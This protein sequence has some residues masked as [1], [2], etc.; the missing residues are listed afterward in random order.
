MAS[1][2]TKFNTQY[3]LDDTLAEMQTVNRIIKT[4]SRNFE[5]D[6]KGLPFATGDTLTYR[7]DQFYKTF[8]GPVM[9]DSPYTQSVGS[10]TLQQQIGVG[11]SFESVLEMLNR[12]GENPEAKKRMNG[13]ARQLSCA[14]EGLVADYF[15]KRT[16]NAVAITSVTKPDIFNAVR[17]KM[18]DL[19]IPHTSPWY[20]ATNLKTSVDLANSLYYNT[21][22][23]TMTDDAFREGFIGT[24]FDYRFFESPYMP[25]HES[26]IGNG[27]YDPVTLQRPAGGL[28]FSV[29]NGATSITVNAL[30]PSSTK[31]FRDGDIITIQGVNVANKI[32][33][34][35]LSY[36]YQAVVSG[37]ADADGTGTAV[38]NLVNPIYWSST[39]TRQDAS[40]Q[41]IAGAAVRVFGS[42]FV[43]I[44]YHP[45]AIITAF[46]P[47]KK[48]G[49]GTECTTAYDDQTQMSLRYASGSQIREDL[50]NYRIDML[51]GV[52][53][54]N[55]YCSR[56]M[57]MNAVAAIT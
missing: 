15:Y 17:A 57:I 47:M 31:V 48:L 25:Y 45:Q 8:T 46:P 2:V 29:P 21:F 16:R 9:V 7:K 4:S 24:M 42:H 6:F 32:D 38:V 1:V 10:L 14:A 44:A 22:N 13:F 30:I 34:R 52:A 33:K 27:A 55:D 11:V 51:P 40:A 26:G 23:K 5:K 12:F 50:N 53:V 18:N 3:V 20:I 39:D 43:S 54:E 37:D 41:P 56:I 36:A 35:K 19:S 28:A 49:A